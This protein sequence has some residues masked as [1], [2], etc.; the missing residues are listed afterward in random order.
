MRTPSSVLAHNPCAI[1][2]PPTAP[3]KRPPTH[4]PFPPRRP[5]CSPIVRDLAP[6]VLVIVVALPVEVV[7]LR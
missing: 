3:P 7:V 5:S 6:L 2:S 4:P 1:G